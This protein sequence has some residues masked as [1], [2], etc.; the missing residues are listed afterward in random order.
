MSQKSLLN[1]TLITVYNEIMTDKQV[2]QYEEMKRKT[3]QKHIG[4]KYS[5]LVILDLDHISN[6]HRYYKCKCDCGKMVVVGFAHLRSGA[7]KS[8]GCLWEENKHEYRK[9]HGFAK[10]EP[11][12]STWRGIKQRCYN[13]NHS[14]Y[15]E[16]GGRG[17]VMCE[18]WKNNYLIFRKWALES[19][20]KTGL[21]I[22][23]INNEAGYYP[24]NCRWVTNKVQQSN[25]RTNHFITFNGETKTISEWAY[26]K[27]ISASLLQARIGKLGWSIEKAL[28]YKS[29]E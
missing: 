29:V 9:K 15:K 21:T 6:N 8:C 16:Y 24:N 4:K 5:R 28:T 20:Y 23:R 3:T 1:K 27:G 12:Y 11:L 7:I 14:R 17:I 18:D 10:K 13:K 25:K 19:G 22:D 2:R 26:E